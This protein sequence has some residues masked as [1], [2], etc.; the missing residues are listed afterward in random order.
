M[1]WFTKIPEWIKIPVKILL[2]ALW[3]FSFLILII[4]EEFLNKIFLLE[5]RNQNGFV[6]GLIFIIS[7]TL[8]ISYGGSYL[9]DKIKKYIN[10]NEK[11]NMLFS[12]TGKE[13]EVLFGMFNSD[14]KA[15]LFDM[16][17]PV[18]HSLLNR[19]LIGQGQ[20]QASSEYLMYG[21]IALNYYIFPYVVQLLENGFF[22]LEKKQKKLNN[23]LK[24]C[25]NSN[26]KKKLDEKLKHC[27]NKLSYKNIELKQN[28]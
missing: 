2:P 3:L 19:G 16:S 11:I 7:T 20:Q 10:K 1:D 28:A 4:S 12:L 15:G 18:I 24:H 5:F 22:Y 14:S 8:I 23:K 25:K 27:K 17:D 21:I 6:I 9:F 26:K 13:K